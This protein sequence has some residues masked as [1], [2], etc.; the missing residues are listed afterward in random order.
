MNEIERNSLVLAEIVGSW[1]AGLVSRRRLSP[2]TRA[3]DMSGCQFWH[4]HCYILVFSKGGG[5][6]Y[7]PK[8]SNKINALLNY[9]SAPSDTLKPFYMLSK[10][11]ID[12]LQA[13][14]S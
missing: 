8:E 11:N 7:P 6:G 14:T 4:K 12:T 9:K 5:G 2:R 10:R 13:V 1:A 3:F